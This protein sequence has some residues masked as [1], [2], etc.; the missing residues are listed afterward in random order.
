MIAPL[1]AMGS[2][3]HEAADAAGGQ[4]GL[5]RRQ[6]YVL[7]GRYRQGSGL[8]TDLAPRRSDGGRG[9]GR[10]AE[11]VESVIRE[12][13]RTRYLKRQKLSLAVVHRDIVRACK[14]QGLAVPARNTV[15]NRLAMMHPARVEQSRGGPDA[16]RPLQAGGGAVPKISAPLQ[17]IQIDHTVID[18]IVVDER[19]RRPIGRPYL[20]AAID[21][22]SRCLV[23]MVVTLEAPSAVS[24]D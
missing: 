10:L 12:M 20:T 3:S 13:I 8:V 21:V 6:V 7:V 14:A 1:A 2:V 24:S 5:S 9:G 15:A 4:L 18:V 16:A 17:Q 11:P 19:D 22:C 23:G